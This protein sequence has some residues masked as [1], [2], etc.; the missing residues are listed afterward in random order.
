MTNDRSSPEWEVVY[1]DTVDADTE[2]SYRFLV[3]YV[4][5]QKAMEWLRGFYET[6]ARLAEFPGPLSHAVDSEASKI[7]GRPT[8]KMPYRG[9]TRQKPIGAT[10]RVY[11]YIVEPQNE[12]E[13]G[14][15]FILRV[16]HGAAEPW[17]T[18]E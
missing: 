16:L 9:G 8:R 7:T 13:R 1:L 12:T 3:P 5:E 11:F 18:Q 10:Y 15:I 14:G 17:T 6:T 4:G 2:A